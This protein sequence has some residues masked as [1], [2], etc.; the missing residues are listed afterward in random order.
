MCLSKICDSPPISHWFAEH[1]KFFFFGCIA[2][3]PVK[4]V[5]AV[6]ESP[7]KDHILGLFFALMVLTVHFYGNLGPLLLR[8]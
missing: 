3:F 5:G 2:N 4:V 7:L 1:C 8:H 6:G